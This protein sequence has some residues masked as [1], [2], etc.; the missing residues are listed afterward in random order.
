MLA[1]FFR[2]AFAF[3]VVYAAA[4]YAFWLQG[5]EMPAFW[6]NFWFWSIFVV[7]LLLP[8]RWDGSDDSW[9]SDLGGHDGYGF[10]DD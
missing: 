3:L 9:M 1:K 4:M 7:V 8:R 2:V 6:K 10:G 5:V